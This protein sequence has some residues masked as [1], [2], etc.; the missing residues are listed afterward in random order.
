VVQDCIPR[1]DPG[2]TFKL[3]TD[4]GITHGETPTVVICRLMHKY[5]EFDTLIR[6]NRG[7]SV[8]F[9]CKKLTKY[10]EGLT[11][12][13]TKPLTGKLFEDNNYFEAPS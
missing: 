7:H 11:I 6:E 10:D 12:S 4:E 8:E 13:V 9:S 3:Y 5:K 1:L 2:T